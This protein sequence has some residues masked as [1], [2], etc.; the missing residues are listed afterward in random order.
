[1]E[2]LTHLS[3][4]IG[5]SVRVSA[6][7]Q[8]RRDRPMVLC[9]WIGR[10]SSSNSS[11]GVRVT[12]AVMAVSM[13]TVRMGVCMLMVG[14]A[15]RMRVRHGCTVERVQHSGARSQ[16]SARWDLPSSPNARIPAYE[17]PFPPPVASA[18]VTGD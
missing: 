5:V 3:R 6:T 2:F 15:V 18:A 11:L 9:C 1:M 16:R 7:E 14:A 12:M 4:R 17:M 8:M 13:P 10:S